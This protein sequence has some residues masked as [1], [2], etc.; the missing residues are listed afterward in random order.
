MQISHSK[1]LNTN[2]VDDS[3]SLVTSLDLSHLIRHC[4]WIYMTEPLQAQQFTRGLSELVVLSM[5]TL[6]AISVLY[7]FSPSS[8]GPVICAH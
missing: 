8:L 1:F 7:T 6:Q 2:T 4:W 3:A 5:H